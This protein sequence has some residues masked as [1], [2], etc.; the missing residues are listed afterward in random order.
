[1][2]SWNMYSK[3]GKGFTLIELMI[4]V[5]IVAILAALAYP[6]WADSIRKA[7]RADG[8][9]ALQNL[10]TS[11]SQWRA[12]HLAYAGT[13]AALPNVDATS[14]EGHYGI[15]MVSSSA[16]AF[17][18]TAIPAGAQASDDC[19]TFAINQD[20]PLLTGTYANAHCWSK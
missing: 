1:M 15:A 18:A 2:G 16:T 17:V 14:V 11:Q 8:I 12:N 20:G 13:T 6:S 3:K 7:K 19:G 5:A 9:Q 4:V 10:R